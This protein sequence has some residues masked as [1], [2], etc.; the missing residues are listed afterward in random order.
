MNSIFISMIGIEERGLGFF[1]EKKQLDFQIDD[2]VFFINKE[3]ESDKRLMKIQKE[4][5]EKF[6]K[7]QEFRLLLASYDDPFKIVESFNHYVFNS[8]LDIKSSKVFCDI[9]NFNRQNLLVL[10]W[11]LRRKYG[12]E[13]IDLFYAVP[14]EY[15]SRISRG[16]RGFTT[17]PFF[18]KSF[19]K[20][21]EKLLILLVGY[22]IDRPLYLHKVIEPSKVILVEGIKPTDPTF[23]AAN[24]NT[25]EELSQ[26]IYGSEIK[27]IPADDPVK[28]G[29]ALTT[30]LEENNERYNIIIS[31]LN[32]KLQTVGLYLACERNPE[33]QVV[34]SFPD[35]FSGWLSK[36]IKEVK[37]F[38]I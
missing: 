12:L 22:E 9:S 37:R 36:G 11:L 18:G 14:K 34:Y 17:I 33:V 38:E 31:P 10:L 6:L 1:K 3:F 24:E 19:S 29:R 4:L 26:V 15:N 30:I 32:T 5:T 2:Y 8:K 25:I 35:K 28:A 13:S 16:A 27:K 21:K 20:D 23:L 7:D